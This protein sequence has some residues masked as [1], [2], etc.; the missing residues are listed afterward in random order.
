MSSSQA[1]MKYYLLQT[2]LHSSS[3]QHIIVFCGKVGC[4]FGMGVGW[5]G[6]VGGSGW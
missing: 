3:P 4:S 6:V 2:G 5:G 1:R